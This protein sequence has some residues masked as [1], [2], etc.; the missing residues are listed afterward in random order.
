ML[1]VVHHLTAVTRLNDVLALV[2]PD[3]RVQTVFTVAPSSMLSR[4]VGDHLRAE[5]VCLVPFDQATQMSWDLAV[6]AGDGALERL[7]GPVMWVPHGM[8]PG[9]RIHRWRG[10]GA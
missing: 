3:H 6:A 1:A 10:A 8:S 4:G 7:H 5:G 9:M 2:E